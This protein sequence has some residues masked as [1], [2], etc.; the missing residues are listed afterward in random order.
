MSRSCRNSVT[1]SP[2]VP[3]E[4]GEWADLRSSVLANRYPS[5]VMRAAMPYLTVPS[6]VSGTAG[7]GQVWLESAGWMVL[8]RISCL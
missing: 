5:E 8:S 6:G 7:S 1:W 2:A 4:Y 3:G